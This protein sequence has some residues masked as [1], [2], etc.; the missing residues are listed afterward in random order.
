[1]LAASNATAA[2]LMEAESIPETLVNFYQSTLCNNPEDSHLQSLVCFHHDETETEGCTPVNLLCP[3][4]HVQLVLP[5]D[6]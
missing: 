6:W 5:C 1:V 3:G 2:L 4:L